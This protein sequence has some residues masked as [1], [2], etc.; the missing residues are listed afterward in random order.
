MS[1]KDIKI[2]EVKFHLYGAPVDTV[3]ELTLLHIHSFM[4]MTIVIL[5]YS[6]FVINMSFLE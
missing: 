3:L 5:R 1:Y 2:L 4:L 6:V